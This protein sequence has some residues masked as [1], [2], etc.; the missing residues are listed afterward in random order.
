M[1]SQ[2]QKG[3]KKQDES[4]DRSYFFIRVNGR[5]HSSSYHLL[6]DGSMQ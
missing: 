4:E 6:K 1:D 2:Q 3:R 5:R